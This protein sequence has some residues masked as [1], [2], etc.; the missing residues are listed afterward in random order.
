[1]LYLFM[2]SL[3][4]RSEH[5]PN[6]DIAPN[7][8]HTSETLQTTS[9]TETDI[10]VDTLFARQQ[11]SERMIIDVRTPEEYAQGHITG[12]R[13]IPL[14][15]LES[16]LDELSPHKDQEIYLVC[17]VGGRSHQARVFLNTKGFSK[18]INVQGGTRGWKAK[19]YPTK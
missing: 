12:A 1:M 18:A 8:Q 13:N 3:S 4:C 5:T 17:A 19:G 15:L 7:P 16:K 11:Q 14:N 6:P 2:L 9:T 10:D